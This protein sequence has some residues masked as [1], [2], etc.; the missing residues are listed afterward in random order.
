VSL[1]NTANDYNGETTVVGGTLQLAADNALGNTRSLNLKDATQAQLAGHAQ[2]IGQLQSDAGSKLDFGGGTLDIASGG[3]VDGGMTGAGQLDING[4]TLAISS[5]NASMTAATYIAPGAGVSIRQVDGLGSGAIANA[6]T[7]TFDGAQGSFVNAVGGPGHVVK[8]GPGAV[9]VNDNV[10]HTGRTDINGGALITRGS[11]GGAG[12]GEVTVAPAG[13]LS[14]TGTVNGHVSNFGTVAAFNALGAMPNP[15][16]SVFT[17]ASGLANSGIVNLAGPVGSMPGNNLVVQGG[18]VGNNGSLVIRTRLGGDASP[19]DKLVIDGGSATGSTGLVVK[20]AGAAGSQTQQ[21]IRVVETRNG[22]TTAA[23][24]FALD[25]RSDGYRFG[26]N[27]IASG[28]FNYR[29]VRGGDGGK[30]QDWY[31]V[32]T[33]SLVAFRPPVDGGGGGTV[34]GPVYRPE[35]GAYLANRQAALQMSVHTLHERQGQ[36]PGQE[37]KDLQASSD[38]NGWVRVLDTF[39]SR[40]G[41][42]PA[43]TLGSRTYVLHGGA[44][45]ACFSDGRDGSIRIGAMGMYGR[46]QSRSTNAD[47]TSASGTVDGYNLGMYA[48][49]YGN[50]DILSGPYVDAWILGGSYRNKVQGL[51][52][53][54]ESYRSHGITASLEAGYSFKVFDNGQRQMYVEPQ[55]QLI[56][57]DLRASNHVESTSTVVSRLNVS[58]PTTRVGL[59]IHGNTD[60]DAGNKLMRP[61]VEVNWWRGTALDKSMMFDG[62]RVVDRMPRNRF[63][64]RIG[65]QGNL[66]KSVSA[67]A[68]LGGEFGARNYMAGKGQV[69]VKYSW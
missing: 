7:L 67:W 18:Y 31:L 39:A 63:E 58:G 14:G 64:A 24:A 43:S 51:G 61:F 5:S 52:L 6:G 36:A 55:A 1:S 11:F 26:S 27:A 19:T 15:G 17:L 38:G 10:Q 3:R 62:D 69:G 65:L 21:G 60:N 37:G 23:G 22:G 59:R 46:T 50:R 57:Q 40:D 44:D 4:G 42:N 49:W 34:M 53:A 29:L 54:P 33:S 56:L 30:V 32:N 35:V 8:N 28:A 25:T 45:L 2:A 66:T 48:T 41:A 16:N 13:V 47:G 9:T 12:A 68:S 20:S